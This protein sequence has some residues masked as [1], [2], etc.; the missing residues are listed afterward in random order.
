LH[1]QPPDTRP[2]ISVETN[3]VLLPVTVVDRHGEFVAGLTREQFTIYDNGE[4]Q[5]VQSFSS[6]A[7]PATVGLVIDSSSSMRTRRADVTVAAMAFASSSHP[8]D[9]MFTVNF[10]E[11]VWSGLPPGVSFAETADQ[12]HAAVA[13][14][15]AQG[16]TALFDA[17]GF[18]LEHVQLGVRD[19]K[20]LVV[21]SDGGDNASTLGLADVLERARRTSVVIYS[22]MLADADTHDAR[23]DVLR[24]LARETGGAVFAP[25]RSDDVKGAFARVGQEIRSGYL[26][27]FSPPSGAESG[28]RSITVVVRS[29]DGRLLKARTR[30]TYYAGR[31]RDSTR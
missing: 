26:L 29:D 9:E 19:R 28:F 21:I 5:P 16:M 24:T 2:T 20:A 30:A 31:D 10:N 11:H 15:P 4:L 23:P 17:V 13:R 27:G 8:L 7:M 6:D 22:V 18:A 14:A 1:Q 12:L 25:R 3:L